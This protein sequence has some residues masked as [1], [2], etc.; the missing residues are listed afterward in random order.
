M[1]SADPEARRCCRFVHGDIKPEN[2]LMGPP[3]GASSNRLFLVDLGLGAALTPEPY[4]QALNHAAGDCMTSAPAPRLLHAR[5]PRL[6]AR[7][8]A[9]AQRRGGG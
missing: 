4:T 1:Q 3:G 7:R 8:G 5:A 2:F 6:T 9:A